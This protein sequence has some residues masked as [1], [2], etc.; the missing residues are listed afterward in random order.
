MSTICRNNITSSQFPLFYKVQSYYVRGRT[1]LTNGIR[2]A[3]QAAANQVLRKCR[4]LSSLRWAEK[5]AP[6]TTLL[7]W[8][9]LMDLA[10]NYTNA[11]TSL[12]HL[13]MDGGTIRK[14]ELGEDGLCGAI[15]C[16]PKLITLKLRGIGLGDDGAELL[17][18]S[19]AQ[20]RP[21][22]ETLD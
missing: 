5:D 21:P 12:V 15:R 17:A 20:A 19:L 14:E 1:V 4:R 11:C 10:R 9:G 7:P 13:V 22:L 6:A 2:R 16:F 3:G 8:N 18:N